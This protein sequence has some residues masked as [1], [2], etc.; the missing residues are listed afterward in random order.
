M[1][2]N[3]DFD[4]P[5]SLDSPDAFGQPVDQDM[6]FGEFEEKQNTSLGSLWKNSPVVKF[7]LIGVAILVVIVLISLFGESEQ[8]PNSAVAAGDKRF[9]ETPGTKEVSPNMQEALEE[10]NQQRIDDAQ[11]QG[12]SAIPTPIA[13]PTTLLD[14]P[15][16]QAGE[17]PL[18]RWKT[19]QEE[20]AKAQREQQAIAAQPQADPQRDGRVQGLATAMVNQMN[21]ILGKDSKDP[22]QHMVVFSEK[23]I[24]EN[25]TDVTGQGTN[26]STNAL[27]ATSTK[28]PKVLV[29][30]GE[31]DYAQF[32][33]E[34]NSDIPGP[35]L[36]I[37]VS[38]PFNGSKLLGSFTAE[39]EYL[40]IKFTTLIT[41]K[42]T[43]IPINAFA[44]DPETSLTGVAT[45]VDHRYLTRIVLPAAAGFIQG[46]G[47]AYAQTTT[48]TSQGN[49]STTTTSQDLNTK[50]ELGKAVSEAASQV[51]DII[52]EDGKNTKPLVIVAAG[53]PVGILFMESITDQAL[54]KVRAGI[55]P[56][57]GQQTNNNGNGQQQNPFMMNPNAMNAYQQLQ[58]GLQNQQFL[59]QGSAAAQQPTTTGQ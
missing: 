21:G 48:T 56:T 27:T 25:G 18:L 45:D 10:K 38:G 4:A 44:I 1:S 59:Q 8:A 17:D 9:K 28:P 19:M 35:V 47:D 54:L 5:D 13:P 30:A 7:G 2:N 39:E 51:S 49:T 58:M 40:V 23:D 55:S 34:A 22:L 14:V 41:K 37:I 16:E 26:N 46:L 29:P 52:A 32:M 33:L 50:Q 42:G 20:R 15:E 6:D 12:M 24:S 3:N 11:K 53:T 36:A 31:I 57:D 43:S